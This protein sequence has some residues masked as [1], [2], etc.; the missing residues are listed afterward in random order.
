M[1]DGASGR[2][3]TAM[4]QNV[5]KFILPDRTTVR[6]TILAIKEDNYPPN[7]SGDSA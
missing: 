7:V 6:M 5:L 1:P 3:P 4:E 2:S